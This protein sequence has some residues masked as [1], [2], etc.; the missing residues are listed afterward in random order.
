[1][2]RK[3]WGSLHQTPGVDQDSCERLTGRVQGLWKNN[4]DS[5]HCT[6]RQGCNQGILWI[7]I[8]TH[9]THTP[10]QLLHSPLWQKISFKCF[11]LWKC[12][13]HLKKE[14]QAQDRFPNNC[15][16]AEGQLR[17]PVKAWGGWPQGDAV[18]EDPPLPSTKGAGKRNSPNLPTSSKWP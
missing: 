8:N 5:P 7:N 4:R 10:L 12:K 14:K 9:T 1:M 6:H 2:Y 17:V 16:S 15:Q 11:Y 13:K 3:W 18:K